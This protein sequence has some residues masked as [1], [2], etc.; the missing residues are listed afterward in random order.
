MRKILFLIAAA[1]LFCRP[2]AAQPADPDDIALLK[3]RVD[4]AEKIQE[5]AESFNKVG[6]LNGIGGYPGYADTYIRLAEAKNQLYQASGENAKRPAAGTDS[7]K[8]GIP[9]KSDRYIE[10]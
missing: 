3:K 4:I 8:V 10:K 5:I 6:N 1:V 7:Q 9:A 2:L